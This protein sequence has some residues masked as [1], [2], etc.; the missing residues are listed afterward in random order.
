[1]LV[2]RG[3][4]MGVGP[5]SLGSCQAAG[6]FL[7][8]RPCRSQ[9]SWG[10]R[11]RTFPEEGLFQTT[12]KREKGE[13]RPVPREGSAESAASPAILPPPIRRWSRQGP[14]K[15]REHQC[16]QA[17]PSGRPFLRSGPG[18]QLW[19]GGGLCPPWPPSAGVLRPSRWA[20][21]QAGGAVVPPGDEE[22]IFEGTSSTPAR[23]LGGT[24]TFSENRVAS[25]N[26]FLPLPPSHCWLTSHR[27]PLPPSGPGSL[28]T[29]RAGPTG[30]PTRGPHTRC[31]GGHHEALFVVEGKPLSPPPRPHPT[32]AGFCPSLDLLLPG[33]A[34]PRSDRPLPRPPG[35]QCPL[36]LSQAS[37][38]PQLSLGHCSSPPLASS[39]L[40]GHTACPP[41]PTLPDSQ[42][43]GPVSPPPSRCCLPPSSGAA[44][45]VPGLRPLSGRCP[46]W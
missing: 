7:E 20:C 45:R 21:S 41:S 13:D 2:R 38:R 15:V 5:P 22:G 31:K 43:Q 6:D 29:G 42:N 24:W 32:A 19:S 44:P 37:P 30:G 27:Q 3:E 10:M 35:S 1:M 26:S 17:G 25:R 11:G 46:N 8:S 16:P 12:P 33:M 14:L 28:S 40:C 18:V 9:A 4:G 36:R 34:A 39:L 23:G